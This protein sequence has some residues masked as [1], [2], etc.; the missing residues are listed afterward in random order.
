MCDTI[1]I[2]RLFTAKVGNNFE[3]KTFS[4]KESYKIEFKKAEET[5]LYTNSVTSS[6]SFDET[7]VD[8]YLKR[9]IYGRINDNTPIDEIWLY[10]K[11]RLRMLFKRTAP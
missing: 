9:L 4:A 11:G 1:L 10:E 2:C 5:P 3:L 8:R 6:F 7:T